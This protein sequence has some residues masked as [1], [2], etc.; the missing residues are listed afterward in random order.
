MYLLIKNS[1][2]FVEDDLFD[3]KNNKKYYGVLKKINDLF[4][5]HYYDN[6]ILDPIKI[7]KNS[8]FIIRTR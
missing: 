4:L 8:F 7:I 2:Y 6:M 1:Y 5:L 3:Y